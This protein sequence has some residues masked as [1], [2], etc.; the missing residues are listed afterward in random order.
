MMH[1]MIVTATIAG[2]LGGYAAM[3]YAVIYIAVLIDRSYLL[4]LA[5]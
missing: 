1:K 3:L 5:M 4:S 2:L